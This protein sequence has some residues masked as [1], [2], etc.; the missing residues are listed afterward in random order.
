MTLRDRLARLTFNGAIKIL[1]TSRGNILLREGGQIPLDASANAI[2]GDNVMRVRFEDGTHTSLLEDAA[3][4]NKIRFVCSCGKSA[5]VHTGAVL[6]MVLDDKEGLGLTKKAVTTENFLD[7]TD[8]EL[9]SRELERRRDR[10]ESER[11][12]FSSANPKNPWTDYTITN[13]Q[14]GKSYRVALRGLERGDSYCTC[15]DFR[16]NTLGTCKHIL[17]VIN[18]VKKRFTAPELKKTFIPKTAAVHVHYGS[19]CEL[20]LLLPE[21]ASSFLNNKL[22]KYAKRAIDDY[23]GL[24]RDIAS[25]AAAGEEVIIYPDAEN[26]ITMELHRQ[27]VAHLA[28]E[29]KRTPATHLLRKELL[30]VELLPY[31]LQGIAFAFAAGRAVLADDMGLGKTIQAIGFA[32]LLVREADIARVLVVCPASV[33]AQWRSEIMK[34]TGRESYL[35]E[36]VGQGRKEQYGLDNFFTICNYEQVLRDLQSIEQVPWDLII[37]DEGQ[38]IKNWEGKTTQTIKALR[39]RYALVLSGTPLENRL[40]ELHSVVEFIDDRRLG[41]NFYFHHHHVVEGKN[42][43]TAG[44]KNL[45]RLRALLAPVLLRRTRDEVMKQLPPRTTDIIRIPP[46]EE[47]LDLHNGH[48]RTVSSIIHKPHLTEIDLLRLQKALL[49]CRMSADSTTLVTKEKLGYSTKL[50]RLAELLPRLAAEP[51]R[52]IILFSE[53]TGMLDLIERTILNPNNISFVRLDGT[54]PQKKRAALVNRFQNDP[55]TPF[56]LSTN[57]GATGI[58]LQAANTIVNVDLPWN[59]AVLE[60]RIGRAHRMGQTRPVH[61]YVM[62]TENTIEESMLKTLAAKK[63]LSLAALDPNSDV[64]RVEMQSGIAELKRRLEVLLGPAPDAPLDVSEQQRVEAETAR[65]ARMEKASEAGGKLVSAAFS[66][67]GALLP[68]NG[69]VNESVV[70]EVRKSLEGCVQ[71]E[72]EGGFSMKLKLP[73]AA[74][75]EVLSHSIAA[76]IASV[77]TSQHA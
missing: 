75:L 31:Q 60:Q 20:R 47:Q 7:L 73:D 51:Q 16:K 53:W 50:E 14:S 6:A 61:V 55:A 71:A 25:A 46:T 23:R 3:A 58:N 66:F 68:D 19:Q 67:L 45:D 70:S 10:A 69:T 18:K 62:V 32:E 54:V 49:M 39:S 37:L 12:L 43:R 42:G 4:L 57:A 59:P 65:F 38:R 5:C 15:P 2:L 33:K 52:K 76:L 35:I 24:L 17:F 72:P 63:D 34:F 26:F 48:M 27:K 30:K 40:E 56:F 1:G 74:A 44:Y 9:I 29:M 11:M 36:G 28:D 21:T 22:S 8:E 77:T 13:R 41:P 64:T